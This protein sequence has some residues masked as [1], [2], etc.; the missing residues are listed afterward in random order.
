MA[1][2]FHCRLLLSYKANSI[3][4]TMQAVCHG[5]LQARSTSRDGQHAVALN[6]QLSLYSTLRPRATSTEPGMHT[7]IGGGREPFKSRS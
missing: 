3:A 5:V 4:T 6:A 7:R 2:H 1:K